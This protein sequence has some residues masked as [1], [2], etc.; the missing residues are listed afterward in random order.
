MSKILLFEAHIGRCLWL[1]PY[2]LRVTKDFQSDFAQIAI[3]TDSIEG[4]GGLW[5]EG[6]ISPYKGG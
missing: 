6:F 1:S 2:C 5:T 4:E 3:Q